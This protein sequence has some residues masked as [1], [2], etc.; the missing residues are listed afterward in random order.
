ML[1][2]P[3]GTSPHSRIFVEYSSS[4][5]P[6]HTLLSTKNISSFYF[7]W[8]TQVQE[9]IPSH[10]HHSVLTPLFSNW[11][12]R[13]HPRR[14]ARGHRVCL[15]LEAFEDYHCGL[16]SCN[17]QALVAIP[18]P[19][20]C[21]TKLFDT[22]IAKTAHACSIALPN[23]LQSSRS[24]TTPNINGDLNPLTAGAVGKI[25]SSWLFYPASIP[26]EEGFFMRFLRS[27]M[28]SLETSPSRY[29]LSSKH[30]SITWM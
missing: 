21:P 30:T 14:S 25:F 19:L 11:D 24:A 15:K 9:N 20:L 10:Y 6:L 29:I 3:F 4:S 26:T 1:G 13:C 23:S 27:Q 18:R 17:T 7:P 2:F 16:I 5:L 22:R 8:I 12:P 28:S